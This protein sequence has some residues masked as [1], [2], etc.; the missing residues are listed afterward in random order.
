MAT[1]W[2]KLYQKASNY[3]N[4]K[5]KPVNT[6]Y[7]PKKQ[8]SFSWKNIVT[9]ITSAPK[10]RAEFKP[11]YKTFDYST[12]EKERD[13]LRSN[14]KNI[15]TKI[16]NR[17][18]VL[19]KSFSRPHEDKEWLQLNTQLKDAKDK[20]NVFEQNLTEKKRKTLS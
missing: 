5:P 19:S 7:V 17:N 12:A 13:N 1:D 11:L 8:N 9:D 14:V 2:N 3:K 20:I 15:E 4:N 18:S 10:Q 6:G 16:K